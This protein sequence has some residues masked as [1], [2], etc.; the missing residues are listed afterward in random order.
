MANPAGVAAVAALALFLVPVAKHSPLLKVFGL[1]YTQALAFHRTAGW[2]SLAFTLLHGLIYCLI[3]GMS[4]GDGGSF[5][6]AMA[7]ALY[8][9]RDCW[10]RDVLR[11][12]GTGSGASCYGYWRNFTGVVSALA[13]V[14]LGVT[15][16]PRVRRAMYRLFYVV[17]IPMAW[18]MMIM[19]VAHFSFIALFLLPNIV[20]YLATT[21]PV[22]V[23]Q[24]LSARRDGGCRVD[25]VAPIEGSKGCFLLRLP[26]R[27]RG[28]GDG[29]AEETKYGGVCKVCV[30]EIS[31]VWHPFS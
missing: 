25:F 2:V 11:A 27:R 19:A 31:A 18:T 14:V 23:S 6:R 29:G 8:P 9:P 12:R 3:Y 22:W 7:S 21:V 4:A 10:S 30:P 20:Y 13:F 16:L 26:F 28:N 17:H 15:S 1:S 5:W 24:F